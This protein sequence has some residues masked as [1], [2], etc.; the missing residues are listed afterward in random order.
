MSEDSRSFGPFDIVPDA[1][2]PPGRLVHQ[3]QLPDGSWEETEGWLTYDGPGHVR[4]HVTEP[5]PSEREQ[6]PPGPPCMMNHCDYPVQADGLCER[7]HRQ[8]YPADETGI[9][10]HMA[11]ENDVHQ[12]NLQRGYYQAMH[13]QQQR[14]NGFVNLGRVGEEGLQ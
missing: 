8:A 5:W 4:L 1:S 13:A 2:V 9:R 14:Q 3:R 6:L 11:D 7:H 10:M 12:S